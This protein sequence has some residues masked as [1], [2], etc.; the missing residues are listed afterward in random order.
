M[1][2]LYITEHGASLGIQKNRL[3]VKTK[4]GEQRSVPIETLESIEI[5]GKSQMT[6]QVITEC[7]QRGIPVSFYAY[8]GEYFGRLI[9]TGHVNVA[10]Q[11]MQY[12][13]TKNEDFCLEL[14]KE[15]I[16]A[17][18]HNQS[19]LLRRYERS[20]QKTVQQEIMIIKR[21]EKRIE[22]CVSLEGLMGCE[23]YAARMY[24]Q[25]LGKVV[26]EEFYFEKRSKRPPKDEFNALLSLGYSKLFHE[27]YA[28]VENKGLN[29]YLGFMHQD[30]EGHP[31]LISDLIEEWRAVIVDSTVMS[32]I[33]GHEIQ[34]EH[35]SR[36]EDG[37]GIYLT[38]D[39]MKI[40]VNK[41]D[42]KMNTQN[43]YIS[44]VDYP[45]TFRQALDLQI[46]QLIKCMEK[47][48]TSVYNP[49]KIR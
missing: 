34:K 29:A 49:V 41:L 21:T 32:L 23:G 3:E 24:F 26:S 20:S 27:I 16:S 5:F 11:R 15:I 35:F 17:K 48:N 22:R 6:T 30:K 14:S 2:S 7:L 10:R 4:D 19:V 18:V 25:A 38:R 47:Q 13:I 9:S 28:K 43:H 1:C 46:N 39:G 44:Y 36:L 8:G 31:A 45:I 33:N 12:E 37:T 40:F 42:Q